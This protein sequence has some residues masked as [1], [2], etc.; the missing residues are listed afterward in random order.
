M[1]VIIIAIK[2]FIARYPFAIAFLAIAAVL[3]LIF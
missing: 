2:R 1:S 3:M